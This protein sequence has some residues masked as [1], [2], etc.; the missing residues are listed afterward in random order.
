MKKWFP[1]EFSKGIID[2]KY[3][4]SSNNITCNI[5]YAITYILG[6]EMF[7]FIVVG[8]HAIN[9]SE[10]CVNVPGADK[11]NFELAIEHSRRKS[12]EQSNQWLGKVYLINEL[13]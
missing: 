1:S 8:I 5:H 4:R 11:F 7:I 6:F 2:A 10:E 3:R 13:I 9:L 12:L